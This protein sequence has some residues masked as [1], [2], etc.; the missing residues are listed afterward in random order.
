MGVRKQS[1]AVSGRTAYARF[2]MR[3]GI[4][5]ERRNLNR[6]EETAGS[7][8]NAKGAK[9][10]VVETET[11]GAAPATY[12]VA[13]LSFLEDGMIALRITLKHR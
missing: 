8:I 10:L 11:T 3:T 12:A 9:D 13:R 1:G 6:P 7:R 5:S 2:E 4:G